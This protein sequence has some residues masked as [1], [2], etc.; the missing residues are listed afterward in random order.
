MT[1]R[2]DVLPRLIAEAE[3]RT[4][5]PFYRVFPNAGPLRRELYPRSMIFFAAGLR[6]RER[7]FL[8]ANRT[9]KTVSAAY[10]VA[11]HLTGE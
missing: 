5:F 9:G 2:A 10:E 3:R 6:Y 8:A 1:R 4:R 11:A 7:L